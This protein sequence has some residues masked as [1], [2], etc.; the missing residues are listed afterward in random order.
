MKA[1]CDK[2]C[3]ASLIFGLGTRRLSVIIFLPRLLGPWK[4]ERAVH[5][6][7]NAGWNPGQPEWKT[8]RAAAQGTKL[9]RGENTTN[10]LLS[11]FCSQIT[12]FLT[13]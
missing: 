7:Y 4:R 9:C 12:G 2:G 5:I 6:E 1:H 3:I 11:V 10:Y 8:A 13:S